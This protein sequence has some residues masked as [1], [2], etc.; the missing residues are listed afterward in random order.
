MTHLHPTRRQALAACLA[1]TAWS[2]AAQTGPAG[3][4]AW[5]DKLAVRLPSATGVRQ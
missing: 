5:P 1:L 4:A 3:A 2:A